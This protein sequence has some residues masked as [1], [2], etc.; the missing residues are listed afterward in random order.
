MQ[1]NVFLK[2]DHKLNRYDQ[3]SG[4]RCLW[5]LKQMLSPGNDSWICWGYVYH[6]FWDFFHFASIAGCACEFLFGHSV[7][8]LNTTIGHIWF[9]ARTTIKLALFFIRSTRTIMD[10]SQKLH[11]T[12]T[13]SYCG[14]NHTF[15]AFTLPTRPKN[16]YQNKINLRMR[17]PYSPVW[18][19]TF[20]INTMYVTILPISLFLH[21]TKTEARDRWDQALHY[22]RI[23]R[24]FQTLPP[25]AQ[26]IAK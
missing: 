14:W 15:E 7:A 4:R 13:L 26:S 20:W 23:Q 22:L 6:R 18:T 12:E 11:R 25:A 19:L 17:Y 16:R 8:T 2:T 1:K 24:T 5:S 21:V 3:I 10:F 9:P